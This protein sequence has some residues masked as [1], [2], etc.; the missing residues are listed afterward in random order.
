MVILL[1]YMR[2]EINLEWNFFILGK[3]VQDFEKQHKNKYDKGRGR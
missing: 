1:S 3:L 2:N